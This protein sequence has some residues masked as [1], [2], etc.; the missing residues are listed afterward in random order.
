MS[1][2]DLETVKKKSFK[3]EPINYYSEMNSI[4]TIPC[5]AKVKVKQPP[6]GWVY[7]P[8]CPCVYCKQNEENTMNVTNTFE[9]ERRALRDLMNSLERDKIKTLRREHHIE[10]YQPKTLAELKQLLKDGKVIVHPDYD[11]EDYLEDENYMECRSPAMVLAFNYQKPN[12]SAYREG[13]SKIEKEISKLKTQIAI[14]SPEEALK[15][16]EAF[17][18]KTIH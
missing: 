3:K 4:S 11:D 18:S 2:N 8:Y 1:D 5:T 13:Y 16:L 15:K 17:E 6:Q 7:E 10:A 14:L 9:T 12:T